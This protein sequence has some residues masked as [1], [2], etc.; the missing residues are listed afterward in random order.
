M[1]RS[2]SFL[3]LSFYQSV[4][5]PIRSKAFLSSVRPSNSARNFSFQFSTLFH[6]FSHSFGCM[7]TRPPGLEPS[8]TSINMLS[9]SFFESSDFLLPAFPAGAQFVTLF[10]LNCAGIPLN[11]IDAFVKSEDR[12][13]VRLALGYEPDD[14]VIVQVSTRS[15]L[16]DLVPGPSTLHAYNMSVA[17]P[18]G[19]LS[20]LVSRTCSRH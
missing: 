4:R 10:L 1:F 16:A 19:Q 8:R 14:F 20:P 9:E 15:C 13:E 3:I 12:D 11:A 18:Q 5:F 17:I 6:P 2:V 7:H